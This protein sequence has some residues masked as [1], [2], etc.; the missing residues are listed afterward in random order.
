MNLV[1][2]L[3][4]FQLG[5]I[6]ILKIYEIMFPYIILIYLFFYI[7]NLKPKN[8][9][10]IN[11]KKYLII[12]TICVV[13]VLIWFLKVPVFRYGYSYFVCFLA[14]ILSY[15]LLGFDASK[16]TKLFKSLLII[17]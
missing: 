8:R 7:L 15:F 11:F 9:K 3:T 17:F 12:L 1:K 16:E 10:K 2:I 6:I 4:G 13:S 14:I 5:K